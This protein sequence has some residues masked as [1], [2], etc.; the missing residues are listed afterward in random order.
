VLPKT[1]VDKLYDSRSRYGIKSRAGVQP[2]CPVVAEDFGRGA[3]TYVVTRD[4]LIAL[5]D[6]AV[7]ARG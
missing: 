2:G 1:E 4:E 6:E 3:D 7:R 5:V